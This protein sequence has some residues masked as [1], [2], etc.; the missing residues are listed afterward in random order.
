MSFTDKYNKRL[1]QTLL[2]VGIAYL[3][4]VCISYF[5]SKKDDGVTSILIL[6]FFVAGIAC[7]F[8]GH[9][10]LLNAMQRKKEKAIEQL[11]IENLQIRCNALTNQIN[12]HFFFNS[13]NS[14]SALIRNK[15][16]N[17]TLAYV[18]KLS[19]VFRYMLQSEKKGLVTLSEELAFVEAFSYMMEVRFAG[20]LMFNIIVPEDSMDLKLPVLSLLPLIDNVVVHNTIDSQHEMCVDISLNE[21]TELVISNPIFPKLTPPTTNGT[22]LKNLEHRFGLLMNRQIRSEKD[23]TVFKVYLPLK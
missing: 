1:T 14:L 9:V 19:E 7:A 6:Q 2:L 15:N 11:K 21:Q 23:E 3:I 4:Y 22:G 16:E 8:V 13:L 20:Q 17:D 18:S 10:F 5:F 12:P